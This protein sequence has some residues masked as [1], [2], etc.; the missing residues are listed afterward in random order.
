MHQGPP[1]ADFH[2][3]PAR[4]RQSLRRIPDGAHEPVRADTAIAEIAAR[5]TD[6][7]AEHGPES[8]A[9]YTG[10]SAAMASLTLPFTLAFWRTIGSSRKFS[11]MSVDQSAK[12]VAEHRLGRWAAGGQRF[13]DA[14]VWM[15]VGTNPLI[16]MQGGYF[17]GFPI[18]DGMRRLQQELR[19]DCSSSSSTP[20]APS[21][22]RAPTSTSRSCRAPTLPCSP[23][24]SECC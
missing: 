8:V 7:I 24:S 13:A 10:T 20:A 11:S 6:I 1:L 3:D 5:L 2:T 19:E 23:R 17:T 16:S 12:W 9:L 18:H 21:S 15:F 22:P 4:L 14:D